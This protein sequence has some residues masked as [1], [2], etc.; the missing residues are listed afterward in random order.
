MPYRNDLDVS[1]MKQYFDKNFTRAHNSLYFT[2]E[3]NPSVLLGNGS[4]VC[5][6][7]FAIKCIK[8]PPPRL[9]IGS[10]ANP[11]IMLKPKSSWNRE[12]PFMWGFFI[13]SGM[14]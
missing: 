7:A 9:C 4:F 2:G 8:S 5:S 1:E 10:K 13:D 12:L 3:R 6:K 11:E 14:F